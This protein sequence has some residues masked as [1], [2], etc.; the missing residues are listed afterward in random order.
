MVINK[1]H[2]LACILEHID[3]VT[4]NKRLPGISETAAIFAGIRF[5]KQNQFQCN[6]LSTIIWEE[7]QQIFE[8]RFFNLSKNN[9]ESICEGLMA[10]GEGACVSVHGANR[11][12]T[13]SLIDLISVWQSC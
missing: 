8:Q 7:Y 11:L 1:D 3:K 2:A 12:G 13:N 6:Q 9:P 5:N 10:I 4:L